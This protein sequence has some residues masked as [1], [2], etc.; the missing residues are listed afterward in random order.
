LYSGV[1]PGDG[2]TAG[3]VSG[4]AVSLWYVVF[5]YEEAKRRLHWLHP[6][7]LIGLGIGL[8]VL[9]AALPLIFGQPFLVT[10]LVR[11]F[12]LPADIHLS[13]TMVFETGIFLTVLGGSSLIMETIA[14]P[15]EVETL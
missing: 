3:V 15:Q 12:N 11:R 6:A 2:F 13:S 1:A 5:G 9:N 14:H 10:T 8:A 7:R 4:I